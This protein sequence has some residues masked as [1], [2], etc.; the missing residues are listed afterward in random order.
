MWYV[1]E[2]FASETREIGKKLK[3]SVPQQ[4]SQEPSGL[5][6]DRDQYSGAVAEALEQIEKLAADLEQCEV[7][8]SLS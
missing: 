1:F 6:R 3:E 7:Y 8:G 5:L 2:R 4:L